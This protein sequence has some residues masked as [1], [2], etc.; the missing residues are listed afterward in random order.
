MNVYQERYGDTMISLAKRFGVSTTTIRNRHKS[1][2]LYSAISSGK[3]ERKVSYSLYRR[4]YGLSIIEIG[5]KLN[6]N[7]SSVSVL[8][9]S[10]NLER[11]LRET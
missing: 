7:I 6:L 2:T 8:H 1:G 4:R 9:H 10:G 3:M 11:A 5:K